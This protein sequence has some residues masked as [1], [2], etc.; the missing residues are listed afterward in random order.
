MQRLLQFIEHN[1]Y[2]ILFAILQIVC[3]TLLFG[4]NPYQQAAFS[5]SVSSITARGNEVSSNVTQYFGLTEQNKVLQE[6]FATQLETSSL[7]SLLYLNDTIAIRDTSR[8]K[9]FDAI[10][11]QVV[12]N[13]ANKANNVFVINKGTDHGIQKNMGVISAE[14]VA[15]IVRS[16][17]ARYS[18]VMSLLNTDMNIIPS[19]HGQEYY[20][21]LAWDNDRANSMQINGLN[22][23]EKIAVGD[24]VTTGQSSL[25]FPRGIPIGTIS[26][27]EEIP[28]KQYFTTRIETSTNFR[29]LRYV[30]VL[31]NLD[32]HLIN[33]LLEE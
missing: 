24:L 9:L 32:A 21:K 6:N 33:P 16:S 25:L 12:Y 22:K 28:N 17:N 27:L 14:G 7:G 10:P 8:K 4:L 18:V 29:D 26:K 30:F 19:I 2:I 15:G 13:T 31:V 1:L 3:L 20:T 23:L 11:A 5:N